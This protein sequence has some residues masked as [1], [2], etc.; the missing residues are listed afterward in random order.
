MATT[1]T[2]QDVLPDYSKSPIS[3]KVFSYLNPTGVI[4][5]ADGSKITIGV[6]NSGTEC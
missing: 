2:A 3:G 1:T 4:E 5:S 6:A